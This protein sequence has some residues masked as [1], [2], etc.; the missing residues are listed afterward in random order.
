MAIITAHSPSMTVIKDESSPPPDPSRFRLN[1]AFP[2][3]RKIS[4]SSTSST[5]DTSIKCNGPMSGS[6]RSQPVCHP[7][8][9]WPTS[10]AAALAAFKLLWSPINLVTRGQW[11]FTIVTLL[12]FTLWST[13]ECSFQENIQ[14]RRRITHLSES[15]PYS[16]L[17][18]VVP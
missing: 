18:I 8:T 5:A 14:P 12:L 2:A 6:N 15:H 3:N 1:E 7:W 9:T 16:T 17:P 4:T 13:G 10:T 11:S